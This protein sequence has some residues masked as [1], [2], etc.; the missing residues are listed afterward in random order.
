MMMQIEFKKKYNAVSFWEEEKKE[1]ET[2]FRERLF[3]NEENLIFIFCCCCIVL[4]D[5][6]CVFSF[7]I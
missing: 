1:I 3:M 7:Y 4:F 6:F 5:C 2:E